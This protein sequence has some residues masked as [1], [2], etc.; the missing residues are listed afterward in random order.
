MFQS[1]RPVWGVT[2]LCFYDM[3]FSALIG[4][5]CESLGLHLQKYSF[6]IEFASNREDSISS[7]VFFE[8]L[9]KNGFVCK[10]NHLR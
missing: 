6:F 2:S 1:T 9:I 3:C 5:K 8:N 4:V 7:D 10:K